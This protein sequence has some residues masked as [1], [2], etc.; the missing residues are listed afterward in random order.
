MQAEDAHEVVNF[1]SNSE[2]TH[3]PHKRQAVTGSQG[4][5]R[6]FVTTD[7]ADVSTRGATTL[8]ACHSDTLT[9]SSE[10]LHCLFKICISETDSLRFSS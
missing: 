2:V 10:E 1:R 8:Q 9:G 7:T 5:F 4:N 6:A 3:N